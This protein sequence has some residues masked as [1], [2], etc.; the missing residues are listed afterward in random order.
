MPTHTQVK[1]QIDAILKYLV[2]TSLADD[3]QFPIVRNAGHGINEVTLNG[4]EH[5][6][7]A[8]KEKDYR[9]IYDHLVGVRAYNAKLLDGAIIQM[10]YVFDGRNIQRHRLAFFPSPYLDE[11]QNNPEIY[12]DDEIYADVVARN[13]VPFPLRFDY[14]GRDDVH[15]EIVHPKSHLTLGQY[16]NCRIPVTAPITP[17]WFMNFI[18]RNFYHTAYNLYAKRLPVFNDAFA[19]SILASERNLV[20]VYLPG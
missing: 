2:E 12:L 6:S 17:Y 7:V 8:L 19:E 14:D 9:E 11:F 20:H 15:E 3:Q 5:V 16:E 10:M 18:L 1:S 4:A 13:L